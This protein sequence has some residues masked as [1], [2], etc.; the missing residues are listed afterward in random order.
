MTQPWDYWHEDGASGLTVYNVRDQQESAGVVGGGGGEAAPH[1]LTA[2]PFWVGDEGLRI[3]S[4]SLSM[5]ASDQPGACRFGIYA[6][7]PPS[8]HDMY[9]STLVSD[10]GELVLAGALARPVKTLAAPL[11]LTPGFYHLAT[12]FRVATPAE[13]I[14]GYAGLTT[15][16]SQP[17]L[18]GPGFP[19]GYSSSVAPP[20]GGVP[21]T[22]FS[23]YFPYGSLPATFPPLAAGSFGVLYSN[24]N[25]APF[26]IDYAIYVESA[27]TGAMGVRIQYNAAVPLGTAVK[28]TDTPSSVVVQYNGDAGTPCPQASVVAEL[29]STPFGPSNIVNAQSVG[30]A[31]DFNSNGFG[32]NPAVIQL[33]R[34]GPLQGYATLA[35]MFLPLTAISTVATPQ[36]G[37]LATGGTV[38]D[39]VDEGFT[40]RT[41]VLSASDDF[42]VTQT[43]PTPQWMLLGGGGGGGASQ[44]TTSWGS[45]G[46]GGGGRI[47]RNIGYIPVGV[48]T[49]PVVV[50][51]G[52][53]GGLPNTSTGT[54]G[55]ASTWNG[56]SAAGGSPGGAYPSHTGGASI[57][58]GGVGAAGPAFGGGGG[59]GCGGLGAGG[60]GAAGGA[61][62]AGVL[63]SIV[64][65]TP[66]AYGGGG[67][68]GIYTAFPPGAGTDG[69]GAGGAAGAN[70]NGV[71]GTNGRGGGGGGASTSSG[72]KAGATSVGG[73]G[74]DG[75]VVI[76]YPIA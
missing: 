51:L 30:S 14:A 23:T 42:V 20:S 33:Q 16:S 8:A 48:G 69:G 55:Q 66:V 9:P 58:A 45:G 19:L 63:S 35:A 25:F 71:A 36:I 70:V 38:T 24:F 76:R 57:F 47:N 44:S 62:G 34:A 39:V 46:G 73:R 61:G 26:N 17:L 74:G 1:M 32:T 60:T 4:V 22:G 59:G 40:W 3:T 27:G 29:L 54:A 11:D 41:H 52:G 6:C 43:I 65:G 13:R 75:L 37:G 53:A 31:I 12:L 7:P 18:G 28:V 49:Y 67:G 72:S 15:I 5:G 21:L 56:N 10:I 50:G 68:G 64:A 2:R